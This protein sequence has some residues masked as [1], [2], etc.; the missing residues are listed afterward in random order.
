MM[1]SQH[2]DLLAL[3]EREES[4]DSQWGIIWGVTPTEKI[5]GLGVVEVKCC[6]GEGKGEGK[7]DF[8]NRRYAKKGGNHN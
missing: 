8:H 4:F 1:P 6:E 5:F 7:I 2:L 3:R